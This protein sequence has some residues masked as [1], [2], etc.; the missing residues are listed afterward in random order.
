MAE[1]GQLDKGQGDQD[2]GKAP[3]SKEQEKEAGDPTLGAGRGCAYSL[4]S[5]WSCFPVNY[6]SPFR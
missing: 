1:Q 2:Q 5:R 3:S 6:R 4:R